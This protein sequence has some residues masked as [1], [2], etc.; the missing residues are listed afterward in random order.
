[1]ST[2]PTPDG[3]LLSIDARLRHVEAQVTAIHAAL[4]GSVDGSHKGLQARVEKLEAWA[5][6]LAGLVTM[7]IGAAVT[8]LVRGAH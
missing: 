4:V 6:W 2:Q 8:A 3:T 1:M 5:H 7:A